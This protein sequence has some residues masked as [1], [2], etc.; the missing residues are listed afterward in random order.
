MQILALSGS[1]DRQGKTAQAVYSILKGVSDAGGSS[2]C[3]FLP[4]LKIERCRQCNGDGW[5]VCRIEQRC[6]IEDDFAS[7]VQKIEKADV[8][9]FA[10]PVYSGDLSESMRGFL[11]RYSRTRYIA[12]SSPGGKDTPKSG[13]FKGWNTPAIALC[14]A[15]GSGHGTVSCCVNMERILQRCGFDVVDIILARR[16]NLQVKLPQ[17]ELVGQWLVTKPSSGHWSPLQFTD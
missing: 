9:V 7:I 3:I 8:L 6:I 14:F 1:R 2:E 12:R 16:Q 5:G 13:L 17:L 10:N 4:E 15:G 11:G